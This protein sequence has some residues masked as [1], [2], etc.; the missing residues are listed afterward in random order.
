MEDVLLLTRCFQLLVPRWCCERHFQSSSNIT[1]GVYLLSSCGGSVGRTIASMAALKTLR[2][3]TSAGLG[4]NLRSKHYE[5][6][7]WLSDIRQGSS[8]VSAFKGNL[9]LR[10]GLPPQ[11][12]RHPALV[13]SRISGEHFSSSRS[14]F[15]APRKG[16]MSIR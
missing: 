16:D 1:A 8:G 2:S 12:P 4:L 10:L 7:I 14:A 13:L 9:N 11:S 6:R 15:S 3:S 5:L